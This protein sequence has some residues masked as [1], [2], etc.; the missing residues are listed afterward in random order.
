ME[1][2]I[3]PLAKPAHFGLRRLLDLYDLPAA[4][5]LAGAS[6]GAL[7]VVLAQCGVDPHAAHKVR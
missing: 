1:L 6:A 2:C 4:V 7:A 3:Y 5:T